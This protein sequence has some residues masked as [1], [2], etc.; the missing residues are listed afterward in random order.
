[1]EA[2]ELRAAQHWI[3]QQ[4]WDAASEGYAISPSTSAEIDLRLDWGDVKKALA[5]GTGMD[6][7]AAPVR[8][9]ET[10]VLRDY[11]LEKLD[12]TQ[13]VFADRVLSWAGEVVR[14][15]KEVH[16]TGKTRRPPLLRTWLGGSAG[17]GKSTTLRTVVQ[18]LRLLFQ[19]ELVDVTVE[20]TAY[21]G[22]A[23]FNI[24]F[25]A[26]TACSSF[27]IFPNTPWKNELSGDALRKLE[28][29]WY[30]VVLLIVDEASFIGRAFFAGMLML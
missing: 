6:D 23:A 20:L 17:S 8:L 27:H 11:G 4:G 12:P 28:Q 21:T 5:A 24:G 25:G 9:E 1:M 16:A 2:Q 26:R 13:R 19:Q 14:V 10:A 18:H 30:R 7:V 3:N 29:Q 22:V 15:Y